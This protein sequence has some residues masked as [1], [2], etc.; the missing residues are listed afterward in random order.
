MQERQSLLERGAIAGAAGATTIALFFLVHDLIRG[1]PLHTPAL[2]A[3]AGAG[4]ETVQ[5]SVIAIAILTL[6]HYALFVAVGIGITWL[7]AR[8]YIRPH[9]LLGA[10][11]GFL[12]FDLLFYAGSFITGI[13]VVREI[14][15]PATL[16]AN[17]IAG[18]VMF[19][20]LKATAPAPRSRGEGRSRAPA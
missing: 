13:N 11:F 3:S 14:G 1:N 8:F 18:V 5:F 16:A 19:A 17:M 6:I 7:I 20:Y 10:V 2:V 9:Y 4:H 12:L 15:W